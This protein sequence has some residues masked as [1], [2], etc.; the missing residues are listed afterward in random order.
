ML[1]TKFKTLPILNLK[2]YSNFLHYKLN[3]FTKNFCSANPDKIKDYETEWTKLYLEKIKIKKEFLDK[4]LTDFEK[5][6]VLLLLDKISK[7]NKDEKLYL[8]AL[9]RIKLQNKLNIDLLK[10]QK[11]LN[12]LLERDNLW[13]KENP[14][15]LKTE[16]MKISLASFSGKTVTTQ[17]IIH[18]LKYSHL[19]STRRRKER[20]KKSR[21]KYTYRKI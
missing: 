12:N 7:L 16:N 21:S 9:V 6:E 17:G 13:P 11:D 14:N 19:S 3:I 5:K 20:R 18:H 10:P 2:N 8:L 4:E 15:W 1:I